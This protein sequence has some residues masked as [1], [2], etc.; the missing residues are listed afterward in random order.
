MRISEALSQPSLKGVKNARVSMI[1]SVDN[2]REDQTFQ[3]FRILTSKPILNLAWTTN[4]YALTVSDG[5]DLNV[6]GVRNQIDV[7]KRNRATASSEAEVS[8]E[9]VLDGK[10]LTD[11]NNQVYV[12]AIRAAGPHI[13]QHFPT[14]SGDTYNDAYPYAGS[15][16][17][18]HIGNE[19]DAE[20]SIAPEDR[21]LRSY[22]RAV[23]IELVDTFSE[24]LHSKA[25]Y[26]RSRFS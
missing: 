7:V 15:R 4:V 11:D 26:K 1:I 3:Y 21:W 24:V 12:F 8:F 20:G 16:V 18:I 13:W 22:V 6:D 17:D 14:Y 5:S 25:G 19:Q 10:A 9:L 2:G 23:D